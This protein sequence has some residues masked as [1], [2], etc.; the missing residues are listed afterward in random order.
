MDGV[1]AGPFQIGQEVEDRWF[2]DVRDQ[3]PGRGFLPNLGSEAKEQ[4]QGIAIALNGVGR[5]VPPTDQVVLKEGADVRC[6]R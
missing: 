6:Q 3:E 1:T 5:N 4:L 2:R